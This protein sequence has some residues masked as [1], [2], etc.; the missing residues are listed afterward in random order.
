MFVQHVDALYDNR[1]I[2]ENIDN[3]NFAITIDTDCVNRMDY[4]S[5]YAK[6]NDFNEITTV[7]NLEN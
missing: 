7:V 4:L 1:V 6:N 3:A 5:V 2:V